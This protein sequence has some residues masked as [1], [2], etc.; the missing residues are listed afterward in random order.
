M[1]FRYLVVLDFEATCDERTPPKPQEVIEFPSVVLDLGVMDVVSEFE[2]FVRPQHHPQLTD[3]CKTF[4]A[5]RQEDVDQ[6]EPFYLVLE[7]HQAWLAD[8]GLT[9]ANALLVTCG[10]WDLNTMFPA[11]CGASIPRIEHVPHIY[12]RWHN[13]KHSFCSATGQKKAPGMEGMLGAFDLDLIGHHHR[14]IDDCR[15]IARLCLKLLEHGATVDVTKQ[16]SYERF[17]PIALKLAFGDRVVDV[18]LGRRNT[19]ALFSKAST[20]FQ[21]NFSHFLRE[22][23]S[24]VSTGKDLMDLKSGEVL[25]AIEAD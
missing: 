7:R 25:T 4:T 13:L 24:E 14:G 20:L 10:D 5:I 9:V 16:L 12:R 2:A 19:P 6:A 3:F 8:M 18:D 21:R 1:T 17:P 23:E 22:D 15:N 11:Q